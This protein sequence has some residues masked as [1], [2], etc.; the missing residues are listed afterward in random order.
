MQQNKEIQTQGGWH[1][2]CKEEIAAAKISL[3]PR[4]ITIDPT[5]PHLGGEKFQIQAITTFSGGKVVLVG[6]EEATQKRVVIKA[7]STLTGRTEIEHEHVCRTAIQR[8]GFSYTTFPTP[9]ELHFIKTPTQTIVV[10]EFLHSEVPFF[11]RK[12]EEQFSF[13]LASLKSQEN[14]RA[15]TFSHLRFVERTF[16][17]NRNAESYLT[18][19]QTFLETVRSRLTAPVVS[20]ASQA[21][22]KLVL[23]KERLDQYGGFLTHTD[24]VPHNFRIV[25]DTLYLLDLS[26]VRFGNK[27]EGWARLVNFMELHNPKLAR[28]LE[29]YVQENRAPEEQESL[30]LMRLI[31][32][33]ELLYFYATKPETGIS[34]VDEL[35]AIRLIFWGNIFT[36]ILAQEPPPQTLISNYQLQRDTL[37][38]EAEKLRQAHLY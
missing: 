38:S 7:S 20:A 36:H 30:V 17:E 19:Y 28:A 3:T 9:R 27:H 32:L 34:A 33:N 25:A 1:S 12:D 21:F 2:Y 15:T 22:E 6:K 13:L 37:R 8:L 18:Q 16:G 14:T 11:K 31:R 5:Q 24:F 10:Y 29:W 26:S 35:N 23:K 4:G